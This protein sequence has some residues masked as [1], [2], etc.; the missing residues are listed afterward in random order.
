[1]KNKEIAE[2]FASM[3]DVM[4]IQ[5]DN[6]FRVNSYRKVADALGDLGEDIED[7]AAAGRIES[8]PGI[9]KSSAEK[10]R[11]YLETGRMTAYDKCFSSF[12][13]GA[14]EMLK[15]PDVGPRTIARLLHEKNIQGIADLEKAIEDG[16][17][18]GMEG[19][20]PKTIE[21]MKK[22]IAFVR[23]YSGRI[24]LGEA[25]PVAEEIIAELGAHSRLHRIESAGSLRR[26]CE[27]I[28]DVDI[29]AGVRGKPGPDRR[30]PG[31]SDVDPVIEAFT[32]LG[33]VSEVLAAG[34]T[35]ASVRTGSGLQVDLRVVSLESFGAALQYF[36][37]SKAHNVRIRGIAAEKGLKFNEYGVFRGSERIAGKTE[38]EVYATIGLPDM[39]PEL[40]EDRGEI[41]AA[42]EGTLPTLVE[43]KDIK[44]ELHAHSNF[45]D[46]SLTVAELASAASKAGRRYLAVTDHSKNLTVAGGLDEDRLRERN[47]QIDA[48]NE[49]IRDLRLLKGTEV[50]ILKDGSLDYE[51]SVLEELDWV[52]ASVHDHFSMSES[53]MT[54]RILAAVRNPHV[55]CIGH[56]TGRLLNQRA[57]YEVKVGR[58]IEEC[59]EHRTALELNAFPQRLD[60]SDVICREAKKAGVMVAIGADVHGES[61]FPLIAYGVAT[62]RRG[63]LEAGDVLNT[64]PAGRL[65]DYLHGR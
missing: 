40:R 45:S 34:D 54:E 50:D 61:H 32:E 18:D 11:E 43:M 25:L 9:G 62:A 59:L 23:S 26:R 16:R 60:I 22:G 49:S 36:T 52:I 57:A 2:M 47:E 30:K 6:P 5:G 8:I 17:L 41:E 4:E 12:P 14:L 10:I 53:S 27:T 51:D 29:L 48:V 21:K 65:E 56:L 46:G 64:M 28:G 13:A 20:G 44:G 55:D 39:P 24:P 35:R 19:V 1:M 33:M 58:I 15:I 31:D 7:V 42:Y 37:G 3:A 38:K 63:W